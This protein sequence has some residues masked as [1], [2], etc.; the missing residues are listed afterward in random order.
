MPH[1][2]LWSMHLTTHELGVVR[3]VVR[4]YFQHLF[5]FHLCSLFVL[6][7]IFFPFFLTDYYFFSFH[8]FL[9]SLSFTPQIKPCN[10][11][12][13]WQESSL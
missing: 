2:M 9:R 13:C 6:F 7:F 11:K 8:C 10:A 3:G 12:Q 5:F 1:F 4:L